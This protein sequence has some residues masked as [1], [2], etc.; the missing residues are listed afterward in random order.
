MRGEILEFERRRRWSDKEKLG[1]VM[2]VGV[3]EATVT[4]VA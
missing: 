4:Q 2:S 3:F 1:F